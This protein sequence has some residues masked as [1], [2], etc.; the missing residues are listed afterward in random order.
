MHRAKQASLEKHCTLA[1]VVED[2]LRQSLFRVTEPPRRLRTRLVTFRGRGV[3]P[4]VDLDS[5]SQL[6]DLMESR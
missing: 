6:L 4:G 3:Q 1:E 5:A 2:A